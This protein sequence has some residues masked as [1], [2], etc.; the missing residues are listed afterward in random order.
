MQCTI[1]HC[2]VQEQTVDWVS[3][4]DGFAVHIGCADQ[5]ARIAWMRRLHKALLHAAVLIGLLF[6]V[7]FFFGS[8][9]VLWSAGVF[10]CAVHVA[11]HR[12]WW[13]TNTLTIRRCCCALWHQ[14]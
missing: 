14:L 8:A 7:S 2:D 5:E 11:L 9:M 1:C 4:H 13:I 10:G 3:T 6:G 12:H